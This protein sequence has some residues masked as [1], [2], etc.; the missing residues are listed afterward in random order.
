[1]EHRWNTDESQSEIVL[2][3]G[4]ACRQHFLP[5]VFHPCSIRGSFCFGSRSVSLVSLSLPVEQ[6]ALPR[7][8]RVFLREAERRIER[9]QREARVPAFVA[10][11]FRRAYATLR[12]VA[13][14]DPAGGRLFC[15]WGSGFGVVAC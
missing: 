8:V 12:A 14:A 3:R 10:S 4:Q 11:D 2:S 1:M 13:D 15:E 6:T 7:D 5:S 9:F